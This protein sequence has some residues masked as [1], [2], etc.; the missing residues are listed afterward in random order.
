ME[1]IHQEEVYRE[2]VLTFLKGYDFMRVGQAISRHQWQAATMTLQRMT[3]QVREL[4]LETLERP[5]AS[6]GQAVRY[7]KEQEAKQILAGVVARRVSLLQKY[8]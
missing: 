4:G 5:L 8:T 1:E 2:K 3:K 6:L 7:Q